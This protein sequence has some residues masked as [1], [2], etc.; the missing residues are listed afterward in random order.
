MLAVAG[1]LD[2]DAY[3]R[4]PYAGGEAYV[5]VEVP[6][7]RESAAGSPALRAVTVVSMALTGAPVPVTR[8]STEAYLRALGIEVE[9]TGTGIQGAS[10]S[11]AFDF[12]EIGRVTS[13]RASE[14]P[15]A[16]G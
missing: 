12:D 13:I 8:A 5:T 1:L 10:G 3:Y 2:A 6:E 14:G 11:P 16:A 9:A 7:V 15:A 4:C